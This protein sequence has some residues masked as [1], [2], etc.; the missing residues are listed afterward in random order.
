MILEFGMQNCFTLKLGIFFK[1]NTKYRYQ[2]ITSPL[3]VEI[4]KIDETLFP[5]YS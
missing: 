4:F 2:I 3:C 1:M 5:L